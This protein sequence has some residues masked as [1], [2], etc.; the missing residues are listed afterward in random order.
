M[1]PSLHPLPF[2]LFR[3]GRK[4]T[5]ATFSLPIYPYMYASTLEWKSIAPKRSPWG[6][7]I[8]QLNLLLWVR[9]APATASKGRR[10]AIFFFNGRVHVRRVI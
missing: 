5:G 4:L 7:A 1:I 10:D 6:I 3:F 8:T 2:F 9:S